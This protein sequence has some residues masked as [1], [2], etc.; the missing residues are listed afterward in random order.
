MPGVASSSG[1]ASAG[2]ATALGV[3]VVLLLAAWVPLAAMAHDL[4]VGNLASTGA[5]SLPFTV[6]GVIVARH[7][8]RNPMGWLLTAVGL[9]TVVGA[10]AAEYDI[11]IYRLGHRGWPFG[12]FTA[13]LE[14]SWVPLIIFLPLAILLFPDGRLPSPRWRWL[15]WAYLALGALYLAAVETVVGQA[16]SRRHVD[17]EPG[18]GVAAVNH[19]VGWF[20]TV[21]DVVVIAYVGFWLTFVARQVMSWRQARGERR[22][23]QKWL[24]SGAVICVL[25]GA[26]VVLGSALDPNASPAVADTASTVATVALAALPAGIGIGILKYR[27]YE[28]DR[29]IS[30]TLAY[31]IV[32]GLLVGVYAGLV[33]LATEVLT[34][35]SPIAVAGSTL[36]VAAL[37]NP[38]RRRVHLA[39]DRRFNR[40][41]Y[42]A[43]RTVAAFSARLQNS[44][45]LDV[46]RDDLA[47]AVQ[48]ALEPAHVSV[49][50]CPRD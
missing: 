13:F 35:S 14:V 44:V 1:V 19:P 33:L 5:L 2:K 48:Q 8:P 28:I 12:P 29:I 7:Q 42:D 17:V 30:R 10:V 9:F 47:S 43:E 24:L 34:F 22:Q 32:T 40:A 50:I 45:D 37:F 49:W 26:L 38:V 6:V 16:V 36:A 3:V 27:L 25:G 20:A 23:Q 39:V 31:T 18:G 41:H 46:I 11:L 21:Q 4:T 15:L